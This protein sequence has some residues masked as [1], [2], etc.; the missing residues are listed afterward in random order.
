[1]PVHF[2]NI[3]N[4]EPGEPNTWNSRLQ[5]LEN[6]ILV[7]P[8]FTIR[9][10]IAHTTVGVDTAKFDIN[11]IPQTA[12]HLVLSIN[13]IN[14]GAGL[15]NTLLRLYGN[16]DV[17]VNADTE[18]FR[19]GIS[20]TFNNS[21]VPLPSNGRD[22]TKPSPCSIRVL[23]T[24]YTDGSGAYQKSCIV[25]AAAWYNTATA[26]HGIFDGWFPGNN[27]QPLTKLSI[28]DP[29]GVVNI[30]GMTSYS[31]YGITG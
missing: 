27:F 19:N 31:L 5:T 14:T 3:A 18:G 16:D 10:F 15:G 28:D 7:M 24:N 6:G 22:L 1:M 17:T 4:G 21:I 25:E 11:N 9:K 2:T 8:N 13:L 20:G 30:A 12:K 29:L 26:G 23:I